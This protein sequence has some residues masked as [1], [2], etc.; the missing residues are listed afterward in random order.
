[1]VY[2]DEL[3]FEAMKENILKSISEARIYIAGITYL[4]INK[5]FIVKSEEGEKMFR[6]V[7][8]KYLQN[9]LS[10]IMDMES[11]VAILE[12]LIRKWQKAGIK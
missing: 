12:T 7:I 5:D 1:M 4:I 6:E 8:R 11:D 3:L 10:I 9:I 2:S